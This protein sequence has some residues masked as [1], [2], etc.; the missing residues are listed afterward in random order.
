MSH[1]ID[2]AENTSNPVVTTSPTH[3]PRASRSCHPKYTH[4]A[5]VPASVTATAAVAPPATARTCRPH[6][7][8]RCRRLCRRP[9]QQRRRVNMRHHPRRTMCS[10]SGQHLRR[11]RRRQ[12]QRRHHCQRLLLPVEPAASGAVNEHNDPAPAASPRH[13]SPAIRR[14]GASRCCPV[15]LTAPSPAPAHRHQ[16]RQFSLH[17]QHNH[18][19]Q[20]HNHR[21]RH[22][23]RIPTATAALRPSLMRRPHAITSV[24]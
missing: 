18:Q 10:P 21:H 1:A 6:R 20:H 3:C 5:A 8:S 19:H 15:R 2:C 16:H 17:P 7:R 12:R 22:T 9:P 11:R 23:I 14:T 13:C 24:V 4:L